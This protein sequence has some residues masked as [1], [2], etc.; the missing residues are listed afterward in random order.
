MEHNYSFNKSYWQYVLAQNSA[1]TKIGDNRTK[2]I[3]LKFSRKGHLPE[4]FDV[5]FLSA[6][7]QT[8]NPVTFKMVTFSR[9][10]SYLLAFVVC[11]CKAYTV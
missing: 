3:R 1:Q 8:E 10:D 11:T 6:E 4:G 5:L 2:K 9:S 7:F